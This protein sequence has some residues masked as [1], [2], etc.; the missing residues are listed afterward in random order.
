M[1]SA[2]FQ[3]V[4]PGFLAT[5]VT[6]LEMR[7]PPDRVHPPEFPE[8]LSLQRVPSP[9]ID[10]YR[11]LFR[12]VGTDWLWTSRLE[13]PD[14]DLA[15]ILS[16]PDVAVWSLVQGGRDVA[17]LELDFRQDGACELA[18][19]GVTAGLTGKGLG[20]TLMAHALAEAWSRPISRL[21]VHTCT[22]DHPSALGFYRRCGFVPV[23]QQVEVLRDPRLT[24][25]LPADAAAHVPLYQRAG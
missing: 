6:H 10:W 22:H 24:G 9:E 18:F 21:H 19:L 17:L 16:D 14:A 25:L 8:G 23:R 11:A 12:Q 1:L 7:S 4:G 15:A 13:M 3:D 2:G 20:G 5:I